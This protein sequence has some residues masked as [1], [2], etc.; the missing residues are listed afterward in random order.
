[1]SFFINDMLE[2]GSEVELKAPSGRFVI[3]AQSDDPVCVVAGGIGITPFLSHLESVAT[4]GTAPRI[5]LVYA[6]RHSAV[7]AYRNR[8]KALQEAI[9]TLSVI[10]IYN[11]PADDDVLGVDYDKI[12]FVGIDDILLTDFETV[13]QVYLCGPPPM[14]RAVEDALSARGHPAER[15][16]KEVFVSPVSTKLIPTGPYS[17]HFAKSGITSEWTDK[18]GSLLEFGEKLGVSLGSGC[19][20]GQCES[21]AVRVESGSFQHLLDVAA[22]EDSR[23]LTCQ[24]VPTGNLVLDA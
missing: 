10:N 4:A 7:H 9:P 5:H 15:V 1:M 19:R 14:M 6:N 24:A 13:P 12:G 11:E 18:S 3:P 2:I 21:C 17:V 23:C 16:H 8:I 22:E 20:A